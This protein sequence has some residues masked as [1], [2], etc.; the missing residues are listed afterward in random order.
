MTASSERTK[1]VLK[2]VLSFFTI[3]FKNGRG[4]LGVLIILFFTLMAIF[5]PVLTPFQPLQPFVSGQYSAPTWL[6]YLPTFLGG[7]PN[8]AENFEGINDTTFSAGSSGWTLTK[9]STNVNDLQVLK[10]FD[11][12]STCLAITFTRNETGVGALTGVS[13]ASLYHDF[14]FPYKGAPYE[15]VAGIS[16]LVNGTSTS[17]VIQEFGGSIDPHTGHFPLIN[18]TQNSLGVI[19]QVSLILERLSDGASWQIFPWPLTNQSNWEGLTRTNITLATPTW[20][21]AESDSFTVNSTYLQGGAAGTAVA[22]ATFLEGPGSFANGWYRYELN[23]GFLDNLNSSVPV[24]TSIYVDQASFYG[25]GRAFG[26]LGTDDQGRDLWSQLVYG[27]RISLI[28]G[29]L[30]A[31]IGVALGLV[32]GLAAGF[33]GGAVDEVLMRFSDLLLCIPFLPLMMV[34]VEILGPNIENLIIIIGFLGWMGFAR[35]I[36]SQ[37]LSLKERP[38]IEASKSVGAGRTHIIVRH[39]LPN[40]MS[41]VYVTLASSVPGAITL[42]ASLAFLGFYDP[43]RMSWGRMLN[44]AFFLGGS[45]SWWW[46]II[47]GLCIAA[48]AMAFILLGFALDEILNPKLRQRK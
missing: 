22:D 18:V 42:E 2:R 16:I 36:R 32:V 1:H 38:F 17:T 8:L 12:S 43:T 40:V 39:I 7:N 23:I 24:Q 34:L 48:L 9:N 45:L 37:V 13:N 26:L 6:K 28:V 4:L 5:A 47:P 31:V 41:L 11:N 14:Y 46:I 19:P 25:A 27:A 15:W 10:G 44:G 29:L 21:N 20:I 30:A 3:F 33:M 35:V